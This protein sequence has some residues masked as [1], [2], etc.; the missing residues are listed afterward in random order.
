MLADVVREIVNAFND[1]RYVDLNEAAR[2]VGR[3]DPYI[4]GAATADLSA[5]LPDLVSLLGILPADSAGEV[6]LRCGAFVECGADPEPFLPPLLSGFA[7]ALGGCVDFVDGFAAL[8]LSAPRPAGTCPD[9]I[10]GKLTGVIRPEIAEQAVNAWYCL[11]SWLRPAQLV[12]LFPK[13]RQALEPS[14]R[15]DLLELLSVLVPY[16]T[17]VHAVTVLLEVLDDEPLVVLHRG[18]EQGYRLW[19]GGIGSNYQLHTLLATRLIGPGH[20]GL[21]DGASP[22]RH[23]REAAT[24]G[25]AE[26]RMCGYF[27]LTDANGHE[28]DHHGYPADI[29]TVP[30]LDRPGSVRLLVLDDIRTEHTWWRGREFVGLTPFLTVERI[31]PLPDVVAWLTYAAASRDV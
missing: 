27:T 10:F 3:L 11:D 26:A 19:F 16:R 20:A 30:D 8:G 17:D 1:N 25:P 18:T 4:T 6:A 24:T 28:I 7:A 13:V 15:S 14:V 29:P 31:L 5:A 21:I 23:E 9:V 2:I 22:D 12:L